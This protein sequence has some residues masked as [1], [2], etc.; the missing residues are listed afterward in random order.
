MAKEHS[1]LSMA[2]GT[3][4]NLTE[5]ENPLYGTRNQAGCRLVGANKKNAFLSACQSEINE[6]S[7]GVFQATLSLICQQRE[8]LANDC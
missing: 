4:L 5:K 8:T 7:V 2:H 6:T 3:H 1:F